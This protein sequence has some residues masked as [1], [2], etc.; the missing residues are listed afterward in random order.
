[1]LHTIG[2]QSPFL[3]RSVKKK[4]NY[5]FYLA[6]VKDGDPRDFFAKILKEKRSSHR[7][8]RRNYGENKVML[9]IFRVVLGFWISNT[10]KA[11]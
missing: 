1:M 9:D 11:Q 4:F 2:K 6:N 8:S 5:G 7:S 3:K 10:K